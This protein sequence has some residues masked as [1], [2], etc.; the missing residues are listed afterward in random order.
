MI[1]AAVEIADHKG[2]DALTMR[3]LADHLG[4]RP[5]AIY[6]YVATKD[7]ILDS[8]VDAV[9]GEVY[10]PAP[11][12]D[13]REQ[14]T[15]RYRSM[16]EALARHPW[17]VGLMET[18]VNPGKATL[19]NHEA[20]L[21]GLLSAGFSLPATA[22]AYAVLDAF[23]YGFALQEAI[24]GSIDLQGS[25]PELISA[26]ELAG[27]PRMT[28]FATQHVMRPGYAFGDSFEVG[29]AMVLDGI[30]DLRPRD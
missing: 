12:S 4:V 26:M 16:R 1:G 23:V 7:E 9:F 11:D 6:H 14:L 28:E 30:A 18:R 25:A 20:V 17:A 3:A 27:F 5:M 29:L 8:I 15:T 19:Q 2:L 22:H 10:V 21:D 24:L 13:W